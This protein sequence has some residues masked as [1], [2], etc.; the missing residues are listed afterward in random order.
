VTRD[1]LGFLALVALGV[2]VMALIV[3]G[4]D[5]DSQTLRQRLPASWTPAGCYA[6][7]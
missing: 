6:L 3:Y 7:W 5:K 2:L 4:A 1:V